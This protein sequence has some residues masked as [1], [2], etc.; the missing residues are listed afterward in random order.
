[1]TFAYDLIYVSAKSWGNE[2]RSPPGPSSW[3]GEFGLGNKT[4]NL[5]IYAKFT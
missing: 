1:M 4:P 3:L 2:L 5:T